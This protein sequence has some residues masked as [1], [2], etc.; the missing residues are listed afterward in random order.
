M[1]T[2]LTA[3]EPAQ[4]KISIALNPFPAHCTMATERPSS[5]TSSRTFLS[6]G[7]CICCLSL[8]NSS[9]IDLNFSGP[10]L[11][12]GAC[13][14][15][16]DRIQASSDRLPRTYLLPI[17]LVVTV[18]CQMHIYSSVL[19]SVPLEYSPSLENELHT[20]VCV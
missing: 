1:L 5:V 6:L 4:C 2:K 10:Y 3:L 20:T 8:E 15:N 17:A 9:L 13:S 12:L 11:I 18:W 14:E 19:L 16:S 7:L